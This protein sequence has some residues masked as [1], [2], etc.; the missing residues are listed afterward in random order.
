LVL[1][2][3]LTILVIVVYDRSLLMDRWPY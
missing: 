3:S 1:S 2:N